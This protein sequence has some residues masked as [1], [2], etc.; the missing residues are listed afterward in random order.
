[1]SSEEEE[2]RQAGNAAFRAGSFAAAEAAYSALIEAAP[3]REAFSNRSASRAALLNWAGALADA[4]AAVAADPG[5]AK[6]H[7]RRGDALRGAGRFRD[8]AAAFGAAAARSPPGEA[9]AREAARAA[10]ARL[11][12]LLADEG[13]GRALVCDLHTTQAELD[14]ACGVLATAGDA[15]PLLRFDGV[16]AAH[17]LTLSGVARA[18]AGAGAALRVVTL[19][20]G[21]GAQSPAAERANVQR[22]APGA[23]LTFVTDAMQERRQR[24]PA[25]FLKAA[26]VDVMDAYPNSAAVAVTSSLV[27]LDFAYGN[28]AAAGEAGVVEALTRALRNAAML[29]AGAAGAPGPPP[30]MWVVSALQNVL[31]GVPANKARALAAGA[32]D[33]LVPMLARYSALEPAVYS[34]CDALAKLDAPAAIV[35]AGALP[36]LLAAMRAHARSERAMGP[37]LCLLQQAAQASPA[38]R[39]TLGAAGCV[40]ALCAL[41]RQPRAPPGVAPAREA[42]AA[43]LAGSPANVARA[44]AADTDAGGG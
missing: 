7:A 10:A 31:A 14:E 28:A 17:V 16:D 30:E 27:L 9:P 11:G 40:Q 36:P 42:L 34:V 22:A 38:L 21:M 41:C 32:V 5:W 6:A 29:R 3:I 2:H 35:A 1:M 13:D 25:S 15:A 26:V 33:A 43:L 23:R 19:A 24:P 37:L 12:A 44:R 8:A 4:D 20:D 39:D 18:L